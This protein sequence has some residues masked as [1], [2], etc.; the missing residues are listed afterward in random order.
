MNKPSGQTNSLVEDGDFLRQ[1][2]VT[3][4]GVGQLPDANR[5]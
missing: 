1:F 4:E 2:A 3:E 5:I